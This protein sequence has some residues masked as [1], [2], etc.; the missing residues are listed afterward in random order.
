M[1]LSSLLAESTSEAHG[2]NEDHLAAWRQHA[3][4]LFHDAAVVLK[5]VDG[6][7]KVA[8]DHIERKVLEHE[9]SRVSGEDPA[10][11]GHARAPDVL[12]GPLHGNR[13][14]RTVVWVHG[15]D[16]HGRLVLEVEAADGVPLREAAHD[17]AAAVAYDEY[18]LVA[19]QAGLLADGL[20]DAGPQEHVADQEARRRHAEQE[21]PEHV[22]VVEVAVAE[23]VVAP[24]CAVGERP[25]LDA[26][27]QH[28][29]RRARRQP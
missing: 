16:T 12:L 27:Q 14:E 28:G 23:V 8:D 9:L 26:E 11:V 13:G 17:C 5:G 10:H 25:E 18:L 21:R 24:V 2:P 7:C 6:R 3:S 19:Q 20:L 22:A 29:Q 4:E 1:Q 15:S